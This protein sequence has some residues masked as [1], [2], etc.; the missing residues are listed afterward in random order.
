MSARHPRPNIRKAKLQRFETGF[1][2]WTDSEIAE[3]R[4]EMYERGRFRLSEVTKRLEI[5]CIL[6]DLVLDLHLREKKRVA[7][8]G[9]KLAA[10]LRDSWG[11]TEL[12]APVQKG[13]FASEILIELQPM[14]EKYA[15]ETHVLTEAKLASCPVTEV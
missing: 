13:R 9:L 11:Q 15:E 3:Y 14:V 1:E 7:S 6:A 5:F 8:Q 12:V 10:V 2:K 4:A